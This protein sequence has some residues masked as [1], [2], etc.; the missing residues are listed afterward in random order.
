MR[1]VEASAAARTAPAAPPTIITPTPL[2]ARNTGHGKIGLV[3][4]VGDHEYGEPSIAV[5]AVHISPGIVSL[6]GTVTCCCFAEVAFTTVWAGNDIDYLSSLP[7]VKPA[8]LCLFTLLVDKLNFSNDI[9]RKGF[10]RDARVCTKKLFPIYNNTLHILPLR[11]YSPFFID[12]DTWDLHHQCIS[13]GIRLCTKR[14]GVKLRCVAFQY[15]GR[16]CGGD[17]DLV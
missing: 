6:V 2:A 3:D 1:I 10:Q 14:S 12:F 8:E 17:G 15:G 7:I 13:I 11:L 16:R 4:I 5:K 9:C